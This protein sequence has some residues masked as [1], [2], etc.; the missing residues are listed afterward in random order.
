MALQLKNSAYKIKVGTE[1]SRLTL[2][3]EKGAV[4]FDDTTQI[5]YYGDGFNW[6]EF[7]IAT[8]GIALFGTG[9][10]D[11]MTAGVPV[12]DVEFFTSIIY[13]RGTALTP[14]IPAQTVTINTNG[15][16]RLVQF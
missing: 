13:N 3:P 4:I 12:T 5:L 7:T 8:E 2:P 9:F 14:S 16:L 10:V 15:N 1:V 6:I 11:A